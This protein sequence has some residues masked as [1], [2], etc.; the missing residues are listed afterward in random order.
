[1]NWLKVHDDDAKQ[2]SGLNGVLGGWIFLDWF[3]FADFHQLSQLNI[4]LRVDTVRAS[5]VAKRS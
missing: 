4:A 2:H 5:L 1:M 3:N